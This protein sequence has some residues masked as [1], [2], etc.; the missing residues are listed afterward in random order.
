MQP[1]SAGAR[2]CAR[3][4][5]R[6]HRF[7]SGLR[8]VGW[9]HVPAHW[10]FRRPW[11]RGALGVIPQR[12][13]EHS[14]RG[15]SPDVLHARYGKDLLRDALVQ[16]RRPRDVSTE[17]T[18]LISLLGQEGTSNGHEVAD[19]SYA[20]PKGACFSPLHGFRIRI[21]LGL[22]SSHLSGGPT[23]DPHVDHCEPGRVMP[24][25]QSVYRSREVGNPVGW[26]FSR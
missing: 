1:C 8:R 19:A 14:T 24:R 21:K 13:P 17:E 22:I 26:D 15:V 16:H 12:L 9:H 7:G 10:Y 23:K 4:A 3:T 20:S 6:P 11:I 5:R 25:S 2:L 18:R